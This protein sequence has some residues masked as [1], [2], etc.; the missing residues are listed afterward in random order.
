MSDIYDYFIRIIV[1][2]TLAYFSFGSPFNNNNK[3]K[4][5]NKF[6]FGGTLLKMKQVCTAEGSSYLNIWLRSADNITNQDITHIL[7]VL[8]IHIN[9]DTFCWFILTTCVQV[10]GCHL[11]YKDK[12]EAASPIVKCLGDVS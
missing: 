7:A 12:C 11:L 9:L 2:G 1:G 3:K 5:S 8:I 4:I 10:C 6:K